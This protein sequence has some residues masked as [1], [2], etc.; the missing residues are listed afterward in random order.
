MRI[1]IGR[2]GV[3]NGDDM[4]YSIA[5]VVFMCYEDREGVCM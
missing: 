3:A 5:R 2:R 4:G 1:R